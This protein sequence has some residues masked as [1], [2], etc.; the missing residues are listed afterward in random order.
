MNT[1]PAPELFRNDPSIEIELKNPVAEHFA[2]FAIGNAVA[3]EEM[4]CADLQK[5]HPEVIEQ[6]AAL[7]DIDRVDFMNAFHDAVK[8]HATQHYVVRENEAEGQHLVICGAGPSLAE[9]AAEYVPQAD[10]VWGCNS[11]VTWLAGHGYKPT[12][13]F[14]VDQTPVMLKEWYSVPDVEYLV[15]T[16]VHPHLTQLLR[17]RGRTVRFFNNYCGI[18]GE[19]VQFRDQLLDFESWLY[20]VL[21]P[22]TI[23]AGQGLNA[24]N[25]A[26]D[27]ATYMGFAKITVLGADCAIRLKRPKPFGMQ[28][29][30]RAHRRWLEKHTVMHAS[31]ANAVTNGQTAITMGGMIDGRYWESKPDLIVSAVWLEMTRRRMGGRLE[32]IGDTLPNALRNKDVEFLKRLPTLTR[33]DGTPIEFKED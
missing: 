31:G 32:V 5:H 22:P 17:S 23:Q 15:A 33:A 4:A 27:V 1:T 8:A 10:Q 30:D 13:G 6:L 11:A 21:F 3:W 24:V 20:C 18:Q 9:T 25:R 14:T 12:H 28:H 2:A 19:P 16:T 26:I 29:G 7:G